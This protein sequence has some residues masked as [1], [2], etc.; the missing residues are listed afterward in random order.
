MLLYLESIGSGPSQESTGVEQPLNGR[1]HKKVQSWQRLC[2]DVKH[3]KNIAGSIEVKSTQLKAESQQYC[4][5]FVIIKLEVCGLKDIS[6]IICFQL[7]L[8][9]ECDG[10]EIT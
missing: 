4:K 5:T 2:G 9:L 1:S 3:Q 10:L 7:C 8:D 6:V